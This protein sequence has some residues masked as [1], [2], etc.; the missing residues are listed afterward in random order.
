MNKTL[1]QFNI[2]QNSGYIPEKYLDIRRADWNKLI[3]AIAASPPE[4][5]RRDNPLSFPFQNGI[6]ACVTSTIAAYSEYKSREQMLSENEPGEAIS[7]LRRSFRYMYANT[8]GG[9]GGRYYSD[10]GNWMVE[11]GIPDEKF[12]KNDVTLPVEKFLD[13]SFVLPEGKD[14]AENYRIKS[15]SWV[16]TDLNSLKTACFRE[17]IAI[18]IPGNNADWLKPTDQ[19]ITFSGKTDW[20]HSILMWDWDKDY[21]RV[22]NW[23]GDKMRKLSNDYPVSAAMSF[24]DL[25][26]NWRALQNNMELIK[27]TNDPTVYLLNADNLIRAIPSTNSFES[28]FGKNSWE[29]IRIVTQDEF[30]KYIVGIPLPKEEVIE[31]IKEAI[32]LL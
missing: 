3:G 28:Y 12:C 13:I 23:W 29:K 10:C 16:K 31:K 21:I 24:E 20:Y 25:P 4:T 9:S 18:A 30:N 26:D 11:K 6:A 27:L 14:N 15:F 32:K 1:K 5:F 7:V 19:I 2:P 17:P 22:A 8:P